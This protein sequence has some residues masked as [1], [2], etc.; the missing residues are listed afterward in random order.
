VQDMPL[1]VRVYQSLVDSLSKR[2]ITPLFISVM[3]PDAPFYRAVKV[4]LAELPVDN[5]Q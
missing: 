4:E 2:G 3:Y 5:G 1:K